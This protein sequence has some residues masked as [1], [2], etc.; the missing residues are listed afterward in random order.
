MLKAELMVAALKCPRTA[1]SGRSGNAYKAFSGIY[2]GFIGRFRGRLATESAVLERHFHRSYGPSF[3]VEFNTFLTRLA[4]RASDRSMRIRNYC[5]RL[6]PL[7]EIV[8]LLEGEDIDILAEDYRP[9]VFLPENTG[10][11][12][13][14]CKSKNEATGTNAPPSG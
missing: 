2:N 4:N 7:F 8:P 6:D 3:G 5:Q 13:R 14:R 9:M 12:I 10:N 1:E 11:D